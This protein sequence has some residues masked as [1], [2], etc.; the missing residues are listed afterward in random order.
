M[1]APRSIA[2]LDFDFSKIRVT[3]DGRVSVIDALTACGISQPH[4][5]WAKIK[6][7]LKFKVVT[8]QFPGQRQRT[9]PV[10]SIYEFREI[11]S[12]TNSSYLFDCFFE[13]DFISCL[14]KAIQKIINSPRKEGL[15]ALLFSNGIIKVGKSINVCERIKTHEA[16][17]K[18]YGLFVV[19]R[20]FVQETDITEKELIAYC[21][22]LI[23]LVGNNHHGEYFMD[24][25]F[26][27][28]KQFIGWKP[29]RKTQKK[30]KE[31]RGDTPCMMTCLDAAQQV[32]SIL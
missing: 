23:G 7:R 25:D 4:H 6:H 22:G 5:A 1:N 8:H 14:Y 2:V 28:V 30:E 24:I 27:K 9:T 3:L 17:A 32:A 19:D 18:A 31:I 26:D 21:K 11:I 20:Y 10:A 15:Y 16:T 13:E 29:S 12:F